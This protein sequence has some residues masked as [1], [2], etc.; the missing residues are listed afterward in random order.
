MAHRIAIALAFALGLGGCDASTPTS[1]VKAAPVE[2]LKFEG[3][4]LKGGMADATASGLGHCASEEYFGPTTSCFRN[5]ATL[6]G[7]EALTAR[8]YLRAPEGVEGPPVYRDV[9]FRFWDKDIPSLTAAMAK[10]GWISTP[11]GHGMEFYKVCGRVLISL[12]QSGIN[13]PDYTTPVAVEETAPM[14]RIDFIPE[15]PDPRYPPPKKEKRRSRCG[16]PVP[17]V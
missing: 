16:A 11:R 7:V 8:V 2:P 13:K 15:Y 12:V 3:I 4:I 6:F 17:D 5:G 10:D 9:S 14:E 1:P